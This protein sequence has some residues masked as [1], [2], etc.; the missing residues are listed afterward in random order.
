MR[1]EEL[2]KHILRSFFVITTGIVVSMYVFCMVFNPAASFSL[3]DIGRVLMMA[4][5]SSLPFFIFYSRKELGKKQML[6][7]QV[8]HLSVLLGIL[9]FLAWRWNWVNVNN[10][11]EC[12]VFTLL[13]IGVYVTVLAVNTYQDKKLADK[14]NDGLKKRYHS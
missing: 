6:I 5:A 10:P 1:I 8:L 13:V 4:I 14:L 9:L 12:A 11:K 7:R 2:L 3:N